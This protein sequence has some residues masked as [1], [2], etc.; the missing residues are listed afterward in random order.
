MQTKWIEKFNNIW[1]IH[2]KTPAGFAILAP[3]NTLFPI[4][5]CSHN[6]KIILCSIYLLFLQ[7]PISLAIVFRNPQ[8]KNALSALH[9]CSCFFTH[10]HKSYQLTAA[11]HTAFVLICAL[12]LW[13]HPIIIYSHKQYSIYS[14]EL[15]PAPLRP[16]FSWSWLCFALGRLIYM[17]WFYFGGKAILLI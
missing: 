15:V 12:M 1:L 9:H 8:L 2:W 5:T 14:K 10:W 3:D 4:N 11:S 16:A 6:R 7:V 17:V 13:K